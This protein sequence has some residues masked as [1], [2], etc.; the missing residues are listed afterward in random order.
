MGAI[1][2]RIKEYLDYKGISNAAFEK[3]MGLSN[4]AFR[5]LLIKGGALGSDKIE[6]FITL[7]PEINLQWLITGEGEMLKS[8]QSENPVEEKPS[9]VAENVPQLSN[10]EILLRE[11]LAEERARNEA[12]NEVIWELKE[13]NGRLKG[14]LA[15]G[16][17]GG[18]AKSAGSSSSADAV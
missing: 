6:N 14:E 11:M 10:A 4:A 1:V 8:D 2:Q 3:S 16:H 13:E 7:Y 9:L 12:L 15:S 18:D 17:K 5:N